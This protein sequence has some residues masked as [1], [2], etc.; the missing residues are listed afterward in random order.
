MYELSRSGR[1][2]CYFSAEDPDIPIEE[3]IPADARAIAPPDLPE[4]SERDLV[5]HFTRL[6][7]R[8]YSVDAGSYPLGSCTMKYNP[9]IAEEVASSV[10]FISSH[11]AARE[12]LV[13][14]NLEIIWRAERALCALTGMARATFQPP[15]GAAGELVGL[16]IMRAYHRSR[17]EKRSRILI[18]DSAHGTNPASVTIA[19]YEAV[20]VPSDH[21][22]LIDLGELEKLVGDDVAG[23]MLTNPNTLGL[24]E[25]HI[26]AIATAIHNAGGLLY[27]D[28]ANLNAVLGI[29][30]PGDMGFDIVHSNLHKTFATPHGGG[31]PGSG[32]VAVSEKLVDFLPGPLPTLREEDGWYFQWDPPLSIGRV[33]ANHGNFG[34]VV[35]ALAYITANGFGGL[36]RVAEMAVL[37]ARY[38]QK[39]LAGEFE[40]TYPGDCMHEFVAS[41]GRLRR[42]TGVRAGDIAKSL[43]DRGFHAPTV[44][45]PLI[46]DEAMMFEPT[47]TESL[48]TLDAMADAMLEI[49]RDAYSDPDRVKMAPLSTPVRRPDEGRVSNP[50]TRRLTDSQSER[51]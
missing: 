15:A 18:P 7:H 22:G 44:Y 43:L 32:P 14:G 1:R 47:E 29:C 17:G 40:M 27:Y 33:H 25:R 19:G 11:P 16:L 3:I 26:E 34:I 6:A 10:G 2:A 31:G 28:G 45:F 20:V 9:K 38:L 41:A 39:R 35:R 5:A 42:E 46:V 48:Q 51:Q 13:Q 4:L 30:R 49:T 21:E 23:L 36:R 12:A 8:Q 24:F 50:K 37:N